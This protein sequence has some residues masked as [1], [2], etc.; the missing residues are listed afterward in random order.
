[1]FLSTVMLARLFNEEMKRYICEFELADA[2][3][4]VL[5]WYFVMKTRLF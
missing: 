5:S 1:M 3:M 4:N 2:G